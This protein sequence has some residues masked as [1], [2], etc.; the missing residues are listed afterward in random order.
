MDIGLSPSAPTINPFIE[1]RGIRMKFKDKIILVTGASRGIGRATAL[2]FAQ[3]GA[4]VVVNYSKSRD[5][6]EAV[7]GAIKK[8]GTDAFSFQCDV[9][10]EKQVQ[11]MIAEAVE[12]YGGIDVL[13]NNAG[14]VFDAPFAARTVEQ[15]RR[16]LEV[17]LIGTFLCSKYA[18]P[19]LSARKG[20]IVNVSSTS[21]WYD[22][23]PTSIDYDSAKAGII[24]LT[25]NLAKEFAPSIRV[26][27]VA[28]GWVDTDMN[29]DL[30]ADYIKSE[31][32]RFYLKRFAKPEE[33]ASAI[34]FLASEDASYITGTAL[35]V[36]GGQG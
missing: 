11:A 6:A 33:I 7:V 18:A 16:T 13:V 12:R 35:V 8:V 21:G 24:A 34:L 9:S 31:L 36:D 27:A 29:K 26:N 28:P 17:N 10:D 22:F 3:E 15:W 25:K 4:K 32:E 5:E 1:Q 14:I 2:L 19:H 23:N 30:P 20:S